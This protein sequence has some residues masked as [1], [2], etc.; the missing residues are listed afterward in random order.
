MKRQTKVLV[1]DNDEAFRVNLTTTLVTQGF[2]VLQADTGS[3]GV[4]LARVELPD[5]ILCEVDLGRVGGDLVLYAVRRDPKLAA[6]SF[7]MMSRFGLKELTQPG[8]GR[9][10][11]SF[12]D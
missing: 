7:I 2:E 4:Q 3:M 8:T 9:G 11:D 5:L 10:P 1:I 12:L 6:I